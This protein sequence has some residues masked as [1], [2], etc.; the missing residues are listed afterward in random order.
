M[1]RRGVQTAY[2][3]A[4]DFNDCSGDSDEQFNRDGRGVEAD[5]RAYKKYTDGAWPADRAVSTGSD[6]KPLL[7]RLRTLIENP[8]SVGVDV[9]GGGAQ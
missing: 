4:R 7:P 9:L 3:I 8:L 1:K 2:R 6:G 5:R